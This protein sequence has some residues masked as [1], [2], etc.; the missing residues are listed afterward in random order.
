MSSNITKLTEF[1]S[2]SALNGGESINRLSMLHILGNIPG[3]TLSVKYKLRGPISTT[4]AACA[5]GL[6]SIGDAY[7]W[8]LNNDA[9]FAIAGGV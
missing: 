3:S 7:N 8:I 4:S 2:H 5:T 9:D 6:A 1:V